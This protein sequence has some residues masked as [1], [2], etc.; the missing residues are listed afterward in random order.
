MLNP[1]ITE[2]AVT[3]RGDCKIFMRFERLIAKPYLQKSKL[4]E[5]FDVTSIVETG[6]IYLS[7]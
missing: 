2:M 5:M 3:S 7:R 1:I 6:G 4:K